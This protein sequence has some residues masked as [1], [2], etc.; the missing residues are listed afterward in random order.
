MNARKLLS[1]KGAIS[2]EELF[3]RQAS[4]EVAKAQIKAAQCSWSCAELELSYTVVESPIDG[5]VGMTLVDKGNLVGKSLTT[6]LTTV[7]R[8]DP[9][10]ATFNISEP[11]MLE[12]R[13]LAGAREKPEDRKI[14]FLMGLGSEE[15]YP[16]KGTLDYADL[17]VDSSSGTY[18]IR[19]VFPNP[20]LELIRGLFVRIRIP[21][22][23]RMGALLVPE[24]AVGADQEGRYVLLVKS[25][26]GASKVE[27]RAVT[28]GAKRG[29]MRVV[30]TGLEANESVIVRGIQRVRPG[31]NVQ[32]E[33]VEL[34]LP[35]ELQ[36]AS[37]A[38]SDAL[39][40]SGETPSEAED[41]SAS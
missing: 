7:I 33:Q 39:P 5:R 31:I 23:K 27:R 24:S 36:A 32:P 20:D 4:M 12:L 37:D 15:G 16:Y 19:G 40:S 1:P 38:S 2:Q 8:Y 13:K 41:T 17:G 29:G 9:I 25:E 11:L 10:Y 22:G 26:E 28:L 34:E 6:H 14:E 35:A 21:I 30:L 18:S 3:E